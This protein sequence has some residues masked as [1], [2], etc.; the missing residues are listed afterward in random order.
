ML[1]QD[2]LRSKIDH[3]SHLATLDATTLSAVLDGEIAGTTIALSA[4][5]RFGTLVTGLCFGIVLACGSASAAPLVQNGSSVRVVLPEGKKLATAVRADKQGWTL[6]LR[7]ETGMINLVDVTAGAA[8][9]KYVISLDKTDDAGVV[10]LDNDRFVAGHAY[11]VELREPS[12]TVQTSHIYLVPPKHVGN[13]KMTVSFSGAA[14]D[15]VGDDGELRIRDKGA[16]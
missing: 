15:C 4:G 2:A 16:L 7:A 3:T 5:M 11:R 12:G 8:A 9:V 1:P 13:G 14:D 10:I 6:K